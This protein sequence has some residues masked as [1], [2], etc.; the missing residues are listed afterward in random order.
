MPVEH[1]TARSSNKRL[2]L[3]EVDSKTWLSEVERIRDNKIRHCAIA[4]SKEWRD[5]TRETTECLTIWNEFLNMDGE[6]FAAVR[7]RT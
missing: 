3:T 2:A 5:E 7:P 1:A 4:F 6:R